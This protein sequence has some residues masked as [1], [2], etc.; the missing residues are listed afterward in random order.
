MTNTELLKHAISNKLGVSGHYDGFYREF[1]PHA[2]GWK[3]PTKK[4]TH[5]THKVIVYQ[6]GGDTSDGP[7]PAGG[8]WKCFEVDGLSG[9]AIHKIDEWQT[10][11]NHTRPN[12]C[13]DQDRIDLEVKF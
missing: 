6:F 4:T 13:M 9:L 7:I 1:C 3:S 5:D 10:A 11:A 8:G 12:T 2:I